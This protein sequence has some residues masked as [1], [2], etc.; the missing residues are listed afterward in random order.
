[1][2]VMSDLITVDDAATK[3]VA[4][5]Q[6]RASS[7]AADSE[8]AEPL[9]EAGAG[10]LPEAGEPTGPDPAAT[11]GWRR[12]SIEGV[13]LLILVMVGVR[14]GLSPLQDNSFLTHLSTGR[15]IL[16]TGSIP[17]TDPYSFT[18]FGRDWTVQSWGASVIY[19]GAE[20]TVGLVGI[21][22]VNAVT[23]VALVLV[24]WRLTRPARTLVPRVLVAG[25]IV[26]MGTGLWVERPL[27]F[28]ALGLA[29]VMLAA[30]DGLDPRWL[31]PIMWIWVNVHGSFPFGPGVLVLL[32]AGRWIDDRSRPTVELRALGWATL[33]TALGAIG[34][35]GP[36]L[37]VFPLQLLS[38]RDAFEGVAEWEP[39]SWHRGVELFFAAQLILLVL[40][41]VVRHR[42]W[43]SI[44]P[45]AVFGLAAISSTR[46]ILQASIVFTPLLAAALAGLG[47]LD[48]TRRPR[49]ARPVFVAAG[50]LLVLA[51]AF[52]LAGPDTAMAPYPEDAARW[53]R[54]HGELDLDD[55]VVTH[56]YVGNWL[57]YAY[58]PDE[59]RTYFDDRVDMYPIAVI[60]QYTTLNKKR[61]GD[62]GEYAR[63]LDDVGA[64]AVLWTRDSDLGRY[65]SRSDRWRVVF[66][67]EKWVVALPAASQ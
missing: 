17:S 10:P 22:I 5:D 25:M 47:S 46:N 36:K 6:D 33:G 48:G 61:G 27:L 35:L 49:M 44:L 55:R 58:G 50:L 62:T 26:C 65:V 38:K 8:P 14:I 30:E 12:P 56:D 60:E 57:E 23:A 51:T 54:A 11:G 63:I 13:L 53:L 31:V 4:A 18:A 45:T 52:G 20:Q 16:D 64:T 2:T 3:A 32:V 7:A 43:R 34:P 37:L 39:P 21:R 9:D 42:R 1:M 41:I 66:R 28:G 59:V 67:D 15:L 19:A 40:A 29:L 24:L